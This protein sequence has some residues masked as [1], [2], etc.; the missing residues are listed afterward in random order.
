MSKTKQNIV[1]NEEQQ[2]VVDSIDGNYTAIASAGAGKTTVLIQRYLKMISERAI[3][4]ADILNL[5]FT[6]SAATELASRA[7]VLGADSVFRTFHS[8]ALEILRK[9]REHLSFQLS[10]T[11][12]PVNLEDYQLYFDLQKIYP[13]CQ[14]RRIQERIT[15]WKCSNVLPD[16]AIDEEQYNGVEYFYALAYRDYEIKSRERGFLDFDSVMR[17]CVNLLKTNEEVRNRWKKK[18]CAIDEAQDTDGIQV[19][20]IKTLYDGNI[21]ICGDFNQA[22]FE[23][24]SA[25][26]NSLTDFV[27]TLPNHKVLFLGQNFR[28][29]KKLV[30]FYREI[31]PVDNGIASVMRSENEDGIDPVFYGYDDPEHEAREILKD[32]N[33]FDNSVVLARTNRQLFI[34][35]QY[36]IQNKIKYKILGK[37][38]FFDQR[39]I[40]KLLDLAK[41]SADPREAHLVLTDLVRNHNL[42]NIYKHSETIDSN[43][44]ENISNLIKM[45]AGKGDVQNFLNWIRKVTHARRS[46]KGLTLSTGHQAKGLQWDHVYIIGVTQGILP[47]YK[48]EFEEEKRLLFVMATRAA[49]TLHFSFYDNPSEF[50]IPYLE[51]ARY[52]EESA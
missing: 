33:D 27:K 4:P 38:D 11:I 10:E 43:P 39:E 34:L 24:R 30:S 29:T 9:E 40:K 31:L 20:F 8:Y 18:Y 35:Q 16:Q 48:A 13:A 17:E 6:N 44:I 51:N 7:G 45:S 41:S 2:A 49:K 42:L 14:W 5:T 15:D 21:M 47:H 32:I 22:I 25:L 52:V 26:P 23:W 36:C 19:E 1:L 46:S 37:K 28:S 50:I 12:I 3:S